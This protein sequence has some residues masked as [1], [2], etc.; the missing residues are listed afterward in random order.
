LQVVDALQGGEGTLAGI[1]TIFTEIAW[2]IKY[3]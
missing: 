2:A 3:Q 1:L